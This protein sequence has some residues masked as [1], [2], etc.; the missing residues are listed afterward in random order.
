[1]IEW[2]NMTDGVEGMAW[3]DMIFIF[4]IW[5]VLWWYI[6]DK[7]PDKYKTP[8][9][10]Q[11]LSPFNKLMHGMF[12]YRNRSSAFRKWDGWPNARKRG[13]WTIANIGLFLFIFFT[14]LYCMRLISL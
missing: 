4:V 9:P 3:W 5:G 1:M 10:D 12:W 11:S 14:Y 13:L 8:N 6:T 7:I 2:W